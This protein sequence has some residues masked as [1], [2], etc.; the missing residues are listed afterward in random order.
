MEVRD[1]RPCDRSSI[2][3]QYSLLGLFSFLVHVVVCVP[4]PSLEMACT[5]TTSAGNVSVE[6]LQFY[7]NVSGWEFNNTPATLSV[8][9][10]KP[11]TMGCSPTGGAYLLVLPQGSECIAADVFTLVATPLAYADNTATLQ[12][13]SSSYLANVN[14]ACRDHVRGLQPDADTESYFAGDTFFIFLASEVVC[15]GYAPDSSSSSDGD[16][17]TR[18]ETAGIVVGIFALVLLV[19]IV[20]VRVRA[21]GNRGTGGNQYQRIA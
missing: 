13:E 7:G 8:S 5:V 14:I 9:L 16:K 18:S 11:M 19:S 2:L 1:T 15:P 6:A 4:L 20:I 17:L 12:M 10:C 21:R 3:Q